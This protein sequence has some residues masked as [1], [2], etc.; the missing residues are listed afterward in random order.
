MMGRRDLTRRR[1]LR[2]SPMADQ[3]MLA[4][5]L[6]GHG[7]R[8]R[9]EVRDDVPLPR[10]GHGEVQVQVSAAAVNNTDLWTRQGAYGREDDPEAVAGWQGTPL[11]FPRIQ[12]GDV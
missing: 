11:D 5:V 10:P 2:G 9:L 12:G 1:R 3:H 7:G 4:A 6:T 8:E